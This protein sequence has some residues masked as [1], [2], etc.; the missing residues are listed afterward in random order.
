M[1]KLS[2]QALLF[3]CLS[4]VNTRA[5]PSSPQDN[6]QTSYG[7][8]TPPK[9]TAQTRENEANYTAPYF[10][11]LGFTQYEHNPILSP[12]P[13]N[14]WE[15][16]YLYNP[17]A[18]VL[19]DKVFLLYRAQDEEKTSSIGLAW[20]E[21]GYNFTR[22]NKP[23]VSATEW[24]EH[25]GGCE[26]PRVVRVNGTFYLTYTGY[27]NVTARLCLATSTDLVNWKKYGPILPDYE[28]VV[29]DWRDPKAYFGLNKKG[30]TKSGA[31]I[32][33]RQPD[34]YYY[35]Q[36]GDTYLYTAN[37]TDLI[38]W[39]VSGDGVPFAPPLNVWEQGLMESGPPPV[40][41]RDG[42]WLKV[43]NGMATG[44][45]GYTATQ[46]S[47]G[48]LLIDPANA[49]LGPPLAR[50]ETPILQP[51]TA[52]EIQGQVDNVVFSEGLV[53]FKGKW[54]LY[55]GAGDAFLSVAHA[56]VQQ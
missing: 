22:Y 52:T 16:A 44:L 18:I 39:N 9:I 5:A 25:I 8:D 53:Q 23:V 12:N 31:I 4:A 48:Q 27:D 7:S 35:M 46:Y 33:E 40:K 50:I 26:D 43:Y 19:D 41:T 47:T 55:F 54:L 24:Y 6:N 20:S 56:P 37:S 14:A 38:H 28:S 1:M 42:K 45:G 3:L 13:A 11:L 17:S 29:Y 15:S 36:F 34:G 51:T 30:W 21:D 2:A 32:P 49:P 10:P